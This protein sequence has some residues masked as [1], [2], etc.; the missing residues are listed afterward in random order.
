MQKKL[1]F[2]TLLLLTHVLNAQEKNHNFIIKNNMLNYFLI[3]SIHLECRLAEKSSLVLNF[4]RGTL[5]L[6]GGNNFTNIS[7]DYRKYFSKKI[8]LTG[9]YLAPGLHYSHEYDVV[10]VDA[11][12]YVSK[13]DVTSI[14]GIVRIGYQVQDGK[15]WI[16][17]LG[18]GIVVA[19]EI[20]PN[21]SDVINIQPRLML[22]IGYKI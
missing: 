1:I 6:F 9:F 18:A 16:I 20:E 3:P 13:H 5:A 12:N 8:D 19:K 14:G 2:I 11:Q 10:K 4:H 17:D 22:G 15:N 7:L 21:Y